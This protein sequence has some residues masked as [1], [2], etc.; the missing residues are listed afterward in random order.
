MF[1]SLE[2][3]SSMLEGSLKNGSDSVCPSIIFF[4]SHLEKLLYVCP[5]PPRALRHRDL[6][7][8]S[9]SFTAP[10]QIPSAPFDHPKK[11]KSCFALAVLYFSCSQEHVVLPCVCILRPFAL[12][13]QLTRSLAHINSNQETCRFFALSLE[14]NDPCPKP[15]SHDLDPTA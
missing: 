7:N 14:P 6:R 11:R 2:D 1:S 4:S 15:L 8:A 9:N 5:M 3:T 13:V 12:R 10:H